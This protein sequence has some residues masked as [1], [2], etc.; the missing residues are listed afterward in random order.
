MHVAVV[1]AGVIGAA[2]ADA[3]VRRG[4]A[5]TVLDA[6][7]PGAGTSGTSLAWLNANQKLP[8][9]YHDLS[10]RGIAAWR[11][12][13]AGFDRPDWFV[14]TGSLAWAESEADREA[15]DRRVARLRAWDYPA[16]EVTA[17]RVAELEP[18][19]RLPDGAR[20]AFFAGE[21]FVHGGPAVAALLSRA[22]AGGARVITG[23]GDAGLETRGNRVAAVRLPGGRR[24]EADVVVLCA[25]WHT[26]RLLE[27][28][29]LTV[30][31]LD[32]AA[33]RSPGPCV[34]T[35][36]SGPAPLRRVVNAPGLSARPLPARGLLLEAGDVNERVDTGTPQ[37][38]LD[39]HGSELL[40]R[41]GRMIDGFEAGEPEHR[42]CVRP[43]PVDGHPI[44][45]PLPGVDNAYVSVTHSGMTLAAVLARLS[46]A[47]IVAGAPGEDL[48]PYRPGRD[49]VQSGS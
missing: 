49:P 13:A 20:A 24:V 41:A 35:R 43:L 40:G 21:A 23:G 1:G 34:V 27:P 4:V 18:A 19:L 39:R 42:L 15:L 14:P 17:G 6:A 30:P 11:E 10:A 28:L 38:E 37:A 26:P 12:L 46:A 16:E 7:E 25:G 45:G 47:E 36:T 2:L 44:V 3:L 33:P 29:G 9:H 48:A 22:T 5:V 32:A 8:R 31:L